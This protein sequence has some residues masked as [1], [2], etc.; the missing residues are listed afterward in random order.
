MSHRPDFQNIYDEFY[1]KIRHY[2]GRLAGEAQTEDL[3]QEVFVK[4][5][6]GLADFHGK[7]KLSTWIYRIATNTCLDK[8][9]SK[10]HR[11]DRQS[12]SLSD[13]EGRQIDVEDQKSSGARS[14]SVNE[15]VIKGEMGECI[16]EF[17]DR[18]SPDYR[19]V[20]VL[21]ELKDLKNQ[22]VADIV[23][24]SLDTVKIRLHRA[25]AKLKQEL[26]GGCDLY[27]DGENELACD[28][29]HNTENPY[30]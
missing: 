13:D 20:I 25:R 9:R 15:Q 7:S 4:A 10:A 3:T 18:L 30:L 5:N 27:R 12:E 1:E 21:S 11:Q 14:S 19:A 24:V 26:E 6:K 22:E 17:V 8:L 29:K 16:T 28:R 23:G 2:V